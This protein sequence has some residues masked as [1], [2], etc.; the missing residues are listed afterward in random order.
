MYCPPTYSNTQ[1]G[2]WASHANR[3]GRS[4]TPTPGLRPTSLRRGGTDLDSILGKNRAS[5]SRIQ[6]SID[7]ALGGHEAEL[8]QRPKATPFRSSSGTAQPRAF[9]GTGYVGEMMSD[10]Q[11]ILVGPGSAQPQDLPDTERSTDTGELLRFAKGGGQRSPQFAHLL[12]S[13]SGMHGAALMKG[14]GSHEPFLQRCGG[15][16]DEQLARPFSA[17]PKQRFTAPLTPELIKTA[18]SATRLQVLQSGQDAPEGNPANYLSLQL[19]ST[20]LNASPWQGDNRTKYFPLLRGGVPLP[21]TNHQI[22]GSGE[23][24]QSFIPTNNA[25][26]NPTSGDVRLNQ[27]AKANPFMPDSPFKHTITDINSWNQVDRH[28]KV[29]LNPNGYKKTYNEA[30]KYQARS[31]LSSFGSLSRG[32]DLL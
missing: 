18:G 22:A 15:L 31:V 24:A 3:R 25:S 20:M 28:A 6:A 21:C 17:P 4:Y 10:G 29:P 5:V 27:L 30:A 11:A 23:R 7:N 1:A 12:A 16:E 32:L 8:A 19:P 13:G 9:P 26:K 2:H 14:E